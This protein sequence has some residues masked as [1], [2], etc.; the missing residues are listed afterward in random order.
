MYSQG[1]SPVKT[2]STNL[3]RSRSK[4]LVQRPACTFDTQAAT[5]DLLT[6]IDRLKAPYKLCPSVVSIKFSTFIKVAEIGGSL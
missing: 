3:L 2:T 1:T 6:I 4:V 5:V